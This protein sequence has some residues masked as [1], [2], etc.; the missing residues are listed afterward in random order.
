MY[1]N[2]WAGLFCIVL[3]NSATKAQLSCGKKPLANVIRC[4][5]IN[6]IVNPTGSR[7]SI[8][9]EPDSIK[10][11]ISKTSQYLD[12][13]YIFGYT[14]SPDF[15][16]PMNMHPELGIAIGFKKEY[17]TLGVSGTVRFIKT[18]KAY[19]YYARKDTFT[20]RFFSD[21]AFGFYYHQPLFNENGKE[22]F[23]EVAPGFEALTL[24]R[25]APTYTQSRANA[26]TFSMSGGLGYRMTK[27]DLRYFQLAGYFI[28]NNFSYGKATNIG[29]QNYFNF[30]FS[31]GFLVKDNWKG[32]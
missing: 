9:Q 14:F 13:Q 29:P 30:R 4:K 3:L 22:F 17:F 16:S 24:E 2:V 25:T 21:L 31:F 27:N 23:F 12:Y 5:E 1:F 32:D 28:H 26:I 10:P 8:E 15:Y 19:E 6:A 11:N 20:S 18:R 7:F